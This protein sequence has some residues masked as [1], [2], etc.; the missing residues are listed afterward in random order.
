MKIYR[1]LFLTVCAVIAIGIL[2]IYAQTTDS[3]TAT[4][5]V[6]NSMENVPTNAKDPT[7]YYWIGAAV[8]IA[9]GL[10]AGYLV[11]KKQNDDK[12]NNLTGDINNPA[13]GI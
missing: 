7:S 9:L 10:V 4:S 5:T 1:H 8:I 11:R 2:S 12:G 3:S 6:A 13:S